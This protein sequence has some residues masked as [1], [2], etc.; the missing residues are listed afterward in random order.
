MDGHA[1]FRL[2]AIHLR[3]AFAQSFGTSGV[4]LSRVDKRKSLRLVPKTQVEVII[5]TVMSEGY[6]YI[7][8]GNLLLLKGVFPKTDILRLCV[9]FNPDVPETGVQLICIS[10]LHLLDY[11]R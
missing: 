4:H 6:I 5:L 7:R 1:D 10:Q 9:L 3:H 2:F 8:P 11:K